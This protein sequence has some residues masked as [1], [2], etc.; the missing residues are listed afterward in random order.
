MSDFINTSNILNILYNY[1][2]WWQ[3]DKVSEQFNKEMKRF[4]YFE[5]NNWFLHE[6]I[7]REVLLSGARRTGKTTIMYQSIASLIENGVSSKNILFISFE[8]PLFKLCTIDTILKVYEENVCSDSEVYYFF[9]EI[10]YADDWDIWMKVLYDTKPSLRIMATG[11]AS[12]MLHDKVKSESGLGRWVV[13]SVPTLSFFEY[14]ELLKLDK[15]EISTDIKPTQM[16]LLSKEEQINIFKKLS[17]LQP[18]FIRYLSVGGFP[19]LAL[20]KDDYYAQRILREDIVDKAIKR[21]LPAI[22]GTRN[23]ADVEK[24]FLYLC[25]SSSNIIS[26]DTITKELSGV[27]RVTVQKYIEQL[28]SANLI[29]ISEPIDVTGKKILKV[30]NKIYISDAAIRNAVLMND[31]INNNPEELGMLAETA[32]FKHI[33]SFYYNQPCK[34]GYYRDGDKGKEIDIVVKTNKF[35]IMIEVKYREK[36]DIKLTDAIVQNY[37]GKTPNLVIT[38]RSDDFGIEDYEGKSIYRIPAFAFLYLL[39]YIEFNNQNK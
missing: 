14:C 2:P 1:N 22:Y 10:Q 16:Y 33:K 15:P 23:I 35:T 39:G 7:R 26:I 29:Y 19:E 17:F 18:H 24:V 37:D 31:D 28:E 8:H 9:D 27:T 25:Y 21:D 12:P 20:S 34:V 3:T 6:S 4:A 32:V 36:S 13:V 11:S 38:K 5:A 30:K